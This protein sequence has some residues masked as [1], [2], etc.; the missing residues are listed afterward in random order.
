MNRIVKLPVGCRRVS[1]RF[2]DG[3]RRY[4]FTVQDGSGLLH[5]H[6][7][8]KECSLTLQTAEHLRHRFAEAGIGCAECSR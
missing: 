6:E 3:T 5:S 8:F 7:R 2:P 4:V 1:G